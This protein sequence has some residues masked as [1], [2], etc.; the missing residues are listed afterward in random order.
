MNYHTTGDPIT[1]SPQLRQVFYIGR[2]N[3]TTRIA[4]TRKKVHAEKRF[5][6]PEGATRLFLATMDAYEWGNNEGDFQVIVTIERSSVS[7]SMFSVDTNI[8]YAKWACMPGRSVCT[9]DREIVERRGPNQYHVILPAQMEWGVS[10]PNPK[11]AALFIQQAA[12]TVC[13]DSGSGRPGCNGPQGR[14]K[15]AGPGFLAPDEPR[16]ALISKT[17]DGR[18][19]F[20]VNDQSGAAF[21]SH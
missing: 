7:S 14:D 4:G 11:G 16:G 5:V 10:V 12:G 15:P 8:T 19:Y 17:V 21:Q 2:G 18:T 9:P 20:S 13:L 1:F 6:V 3:A